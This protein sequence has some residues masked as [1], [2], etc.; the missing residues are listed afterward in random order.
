[1][2][3][4]VHSD[5]TSEEFRSLL[6]QQSD[7]QLLD[8]CLHDDQTPYVF[9]PKPATWHGFRNQLASE[10]EAA[11]GD[12]RVVG[13]GR[14]GFSMK[15]GHNLRGFRDTSDIDVVI[16]NA[17]LFDRLWLAL[18]EAAYPRGLI[19]SRFGGWLETRR[20]ELYTGWLTPL[21]IRLDAKIFGSKAKP[22]LDFNVRWFNA[23]KKASRLSVRRHE[24]ITGRLYRTWRYAELYHL[25]S[26]AQLRKTLA[27]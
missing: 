15:P 8:P 11:P 13:S 5:M 14:F 4:D 17:G 2:S 12:V 21:K 20:N 9:E 10:L 22:V 18:L 6:Q 7:L 16:V 3:L 26:L 19:S 24:D 1:M 27:E 25:D 23:L